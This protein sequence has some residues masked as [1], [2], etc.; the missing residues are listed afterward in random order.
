MA[1]SDE[2]RKEFQLRIKP[3]KEKIAELMKKEKEDSMKAKSAE[4]YEEKKK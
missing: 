3:I 4:K 2:E 1:I